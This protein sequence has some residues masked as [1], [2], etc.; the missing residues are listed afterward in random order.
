MHAPTL[1][2][3]PPA[4][5]HLAQTLG[6]SLESVGV[7]L[8]SGLW[9]QIVWVLLPLI[10]FALVF[11]W[12]EV[13]VQKRLVQRFGWRAALWTGWIGT[14]IHEASHV[15]LCWVFGHE[16]EAVALFEPDE[17]E[18]RLG[19]VRHSYHRHSWW[20]ETG[21]WF[22]GIAPLMGGSSVL[23]LVTWALYPQ[24]IEAISTV[25]TVTASAAP[26]TDDPPSWIVSLLTWIPS[27]SSAALS[28][29]DP[30]SLRFW[31]YLYLVL[32]ITLHM[33]PSASDYR[34]GL[35]GGL[36]LLVAWLTMH[37]AHALFGLSAAAWFPLLQPLWTVLLTLMGLATALALST[38]VAVYLATL[39]WDQWPRT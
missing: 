18:G 9:Q 19:Y 2:P 29:F 31:L 1:A 16:I 30:L 36:L 23:L 24:I 13:V 4:A 26:G 34:G 11:H 39:A 22:I 15:L 21:N 7:N 3:P 17:Q 37:L 33:A 5:Q 10:G 12:M 14:P 35:K 28:T 27:L 32:C 25:P 20:Q 6:T 38:A 8:W